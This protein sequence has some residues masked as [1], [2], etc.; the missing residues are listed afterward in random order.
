MA[1]APAHTK[2]DIISRRNSCRGEQYWK[3]ERKGIF[4][5]VSDWKEQLNDFMNQNNNA[6]VFCF[7]LENWAKDNFDEIAGI[8]NGKSEYLDVNNEVKSIALLQSALSE[9]ILLKIN[10]GNMEYVE[11]F[12]KQNQNIPTFL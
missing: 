3:D 7:Y 12:R 2:Q 1:D 8:G 6:N 9:T 4:K 11:E 5:N 10:N